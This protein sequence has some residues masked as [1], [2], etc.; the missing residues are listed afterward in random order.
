MILSKFVKLVWENPFQ[1]NYFFPVSTSLQRRVWSMDSPMTLK[2]LLP[3]GNLLPPPTP[4]P[5]ILLVF[6]TKPKA[7][8]EEKE[9]WT[10]EVK[11]KETKTWRLRPGP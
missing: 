3:Q 2:S 6:Y 11:D 4:A 9:E 1:Q 10:Q 8:G 5:P 7:Q